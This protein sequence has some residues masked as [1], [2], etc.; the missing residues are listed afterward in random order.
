VQPTPIF[1][2]S[3]IIELSKRDGSDPTLKRV[4]LLLPRRGCPLSHVAV[5]ELINGV[6]LSKRDQVSDSL[7]PIIFASQLSRRKVLWSPIS[8]VQKEL[9]GL[10][11][12]R[13]QKSSRDLHLWLGRIIAP[14]FKDAF[15]AGGVKGT[16]LGRIKSLFDVIKQAHCN[17]LVQ[18]LDRVHPNWRSERESS[19]SSLPENERE[20]LKRTYPVDKWRSDCAESFLD[21]LKLEQTSENTEALRGACDAYFT[22]MVNLIRDS[23][24]SNY[25]FEDNPNDFHDGIQLLYLA[26]PSYCFVT[27]DTHLVTRVAKSSQRD[28]ILTLDEFISAQA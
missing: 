17:Y 8:F 20:K 12:S 5:L 25:H 4:R 26:R 6:C 28:R 24:V 1:D 10:E 7:K 19:G 3:A 13:H 27:A 2:T 21:A 9:F 22:F 16:N 18:F 23:L 15:I 14:K 11:D